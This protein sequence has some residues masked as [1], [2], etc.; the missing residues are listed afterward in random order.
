MPRN[1]Q[2]TSVSAAVVI[3][4]VGIIAAP[5]L[6]EEYRMTALGLDEQSSIPTGI[7]E[8]GFEPVTV[9]GYLKKKTTLK[10]KATV[11]KKKTAWTTDLLPGFDVDRENWANDVQQRYIGPTSQPHYEAVGAAENDLGLVKPVRWTHDGEGPWMMEPLPTM[12]VDAEGEVLGIIYGADDR[13]DLFMYT[14]QHSDDVFGNRV[15]V[16]SQSGAGDAQSEAAAV[17]LGFPPDVQGSDT[18]GNAGVVSIAD[19]IY[20]IGAADDAGMALPMLWTWGTDQNPEDAMLT[21]LPLL[22]GGQE[23]EPLVVLENADI[24]IAGWSENAEGAMR[25]VSWTKPIG[26]GWMVADIGVIDGDDAGMVLGGIYHKGGIS[27]VGSSINELGKKKTAAKWFKSMP[28]PG[29]WI[30]TD[31][32][33]ATLMHKVMPQ[34]ATGVD[35]MGR[36]VGYGAAPP[37]QILAFA[38]ADTDTTGPYAYTLTPE[39]PTGTGDTPRAA[40]LEVDAYPNPFNPTVTVEVTGTRAAPAKVTVHDAEGRYVTTLFEGRLDGSGAARVR[41]DG[42]STSGTTVASG[43]YFVRVQAAGQVA[44]RRVVLLK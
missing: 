5:A 20:L 40:A 22:P 28:S 37:D 10:K 19:L 4:V 25:P 1:V 27:L 44:S 9:S 6:V 17:G 18:W 23:G 35:A 30:L 39:P 12:D 3:A 16:W 43:V 31:L 8:L 29:G 14:G 42:V 41:W 15:V 2:Y 24:L 33:Q 32:S 7:A 26:A 34:V 36:I 13:L 11:W 38:P 21:P